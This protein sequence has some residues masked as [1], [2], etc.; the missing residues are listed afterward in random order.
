MVILRHHFPEEC[1]NNKKKKKQVKI[2]TYLNNACFSSRHKPFVSWS[3]GDFR[4]ERRVTFF[5][6]T[7]LPWAGSRRATISV[8]I[9]NFSSSFFSRILLS[10]FILTQLLCISQVVNGNGQEYIEKSICLLVKGS[11][12]SFIF[13]DQKPIIIFR[14]LTSTSLCSPHYIV[15][16]WSREEIDFLRNYQFIF[17]MMITVFSRISA[18]P[19]KRRI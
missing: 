1:N 5:T 3:P 18:A 15:L 12:F 11:N 19:I 16:K 8:L 2:L 9:Y 10:L 17:S 13:Q 4:S 6:Q 14:G 7:S